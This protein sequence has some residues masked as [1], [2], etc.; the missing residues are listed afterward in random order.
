MKAFWESSA[1][2]DLWQ[3]WWGHEVEGVT[4]RQGIWNDSPALDWLKS[5][6][7]DV[8]LSSS[9]R[10]IDVGL[11]DILKG[12][13]VD[14]FKDNLDS[15]MLYNVMYAQFADAG[16]F[17]PVQIGNTNY[18]T[19]ATVWDLDI[20]SVVGHCQELGYADSDIVVDTIM[21]SQ[22]DLTEKDTSSYNSV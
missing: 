3:S 11:T 15:D 4:L 2:N 7:S 22:K 16:V 8:N 1:N 5:E 13:Y 9:Q 6:M 19:G 17:P 10:W 18:L 21:T 14:F 20:F 12:T